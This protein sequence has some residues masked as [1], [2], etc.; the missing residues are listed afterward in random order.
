[1]MNI[2][3]LLNKYF[4]GE[5]TLEEERML[6]TYFNQDNLPEHLKEFAPM[7]NYIEDERVAL[8]VL[9]EISDASPALTVTKKRKA[10]LSKSL[11]IS[12]VAAACIIA[13]FFLFSPGKSN[14]NGSESYAW[15]NGKRITDKE[16]IKMFAE[17]SLENV[18]SHENIF[19]EQMSAIFEE[20]IG[21]E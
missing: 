14:S 11:Y 17:K 2:D 10:I 16:E 20:N 7:F 1:M 6:R 12:A 19:L 3:G 15:I 21:E 9:K 13:V 5:T 8:E 4:D 18:S